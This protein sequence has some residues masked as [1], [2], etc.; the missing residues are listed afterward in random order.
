M[1]RRRSCD[2]AT[3]I[4]EEATRAASRLCDGVGACDGRGTL[5]KLSL[6]RLAGMGELSELPSIGVRARGAVKVFDGGRMKGGQ[7]N[8]LGDGMGVACPDEACAAGAE[9]SG[10]GKA[11]IPARRT[12]DAAPSVG[13]LETATGAETVAEL[14]PMVW[15]EPCECLRD[16]KAL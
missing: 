8:G 7:A 10:K 15:D 11:P 16:L 6:V 4:G 1:G 14:L 2:L 9:V 13:A 3:A 5:L 12:V